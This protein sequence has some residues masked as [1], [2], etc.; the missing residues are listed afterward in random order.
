MLVCL[1]TDIF[2][3]I[4]LALEIAVQYLKYL[5]L[6]DAC[7]PEKQQSLYLN[8]KHCFGYLQCIVV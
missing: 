8:V 4:F 3:L 6:S 1:M 2:R 7:V 5:S